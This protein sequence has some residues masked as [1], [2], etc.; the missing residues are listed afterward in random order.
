MVR[1]L[2]WEQLCWPH[3][4]SVM[5][6]GVHVCVLGVVHCVSLG[7]KN[8]VVLPDAAVGPLGGLQRGWVAPCVTCL[9]CLTQGTLQATGATCWL[10]VQGRR[11]TTGAPSQQA[12]R[13]RQELAAVWAPGRKLLEPALQGAA[14]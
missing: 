13:E 14:G 12:Q 3:L 4:L 11:Q 10:S 2:Q 5:V 9:F 1:L 6:L 7:E 8:R